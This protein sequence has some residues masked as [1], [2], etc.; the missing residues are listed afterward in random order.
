MQLRDGKIVKDGIFWPTE[1]DRQPISIDGY[2]P[3]GIPGSLQVVE[4]TRVQS[5]GSIE[6]D[7]K[8]IF[9][10]Y[11][12]FRTGQATLSILTGNV[13]IKQSRRWE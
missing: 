3:T 7:L 2:F 6:S 11:R 10:L 13:T 9:P 12:A 1:L 8:K 4:E 5:P